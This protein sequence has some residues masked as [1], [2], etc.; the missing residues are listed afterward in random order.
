MALGLQT[1]IANTG[2]GFYLDKCFSSIVYCAINEVDCEH[3]SSQLMAQ[4]LLTATGPLPVLAVVLW[5][6][7]LFF[8]LNS[9]L[10]KS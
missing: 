4:G 5:R 8:Y 9:E 7:N 2:S 10:S 1:A 3:V 6:L